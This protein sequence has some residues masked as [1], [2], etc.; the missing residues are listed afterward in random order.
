MQEVETGKAPMSWNQYQALLA[1]GKVQKIG[2]PE[3][4]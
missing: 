3:H 2:P 1:E 4:V